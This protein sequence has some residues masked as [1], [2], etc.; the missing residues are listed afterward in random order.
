MRGSTEALGPAETRSSCPYLRR[1][2]MPCSDKIFIDTSLGTR[3]PVG[4]CR[5]SVAG[6]A[7]AV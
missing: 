3:S 7:E 4:S 5:F 1:L 2:D 6:E